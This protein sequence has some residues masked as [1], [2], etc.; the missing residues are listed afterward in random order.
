MSAR[1]FLVIGYVGMLMG[2][3]A[4]ISLLVSAVLL[5]WLGIDRF[6]TLMSAAIQFGAALCIVSIGVRL[7]A[8]TWLWF[9]SRMAQSHG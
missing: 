3:G 4:V 1:V 7:I 5:S 8:A 9:K 2:S 6:G